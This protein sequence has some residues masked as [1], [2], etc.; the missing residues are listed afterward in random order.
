MV[1]MKVVNHDI[2]NISGKNIV[3]IVIIEAYEKV[4]IYK[5][6]EFVGYR[7]EGYGLYKDASFHLTDNLYLFKWESFSSS[8]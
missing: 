3:H 1:I 8:D 6:A 4:D 2:Y 5:I 7:V